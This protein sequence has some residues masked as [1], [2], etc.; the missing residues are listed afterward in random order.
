MSRLP[1]KF[2]I[3]CPSAIGHLNPMSVLASELKHRGHEIVFF[4]LPEV[5]RMLTIAGMEHVVIGEREFPEGSL[6]QHYEELGKLNG[7]AGVRRIVAFQLSSMKMSFREIPDAIKA[8][9]ISALLID[10]I[11]GTFGAT[12]AEHCGIPFV[13]I[14]NAL[15]VNREDSVPPFTTMWAYWESWLG[16]LRNR[17]SNRVVE[18]ILHPVLDLANKQRQTWTLRPCWNADDFDSPLATICQIPRGFDFPR[19]GAA[20]RFHYVGPLLAASRR[21]PLNLASTSFPFH[22]LTGK[23]L[24]YASLGTLQNR[25]FNVFRIIAAASCD[26]D[27]QL[28]ISLGDPNATLPEWPLPGAPVVVS[29]APHQ[30]LIDRAA[31]VITHAGLNTV[32]GALSSGVPVVAIPVTSEQP[33]I[34]AR[35]KRTGAGEALAISQLEVSRLRALV[36]QVLTAESYRQKACVMQE[37][38]RKSGGVSR[39]AEILLQALTTGH[40]THEEN[41]A[42]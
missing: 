2:G 14:C 22:K 25:V 37:A 38:I 8:C 3:L 9:R 19:K 32:M 16:R 27:V 39:A 18:H 23:P 42:D 4:C 12:I 6:K 21:E 35:L 20:R 17:V 5:A 40:Q 33:G 30:Q 1:F 24:I 36:Q 11:S 15:P 41:L 31:L 28:V 10:Q 7:L 13:T 34:A 26:L 29:Y